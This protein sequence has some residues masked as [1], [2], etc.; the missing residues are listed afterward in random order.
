MKKQR[1]EYDLFEESY[2]I[3]IAAELIVAIEKVK[4]GPF[5]NLKGE[6]DLRVGGKTRISSEKKIPPTTCDGI[7]KLVL[8]CGLLLGIRC[9]L[10]FGHDT[11]EVDQT[12]PL[13]A[14]RSRPV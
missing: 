4:Q 10:V 8:L 1:L 6:P 7:P 5:Q 12:W 11:V 9:L 14:D 13:R 3:Q 2:I